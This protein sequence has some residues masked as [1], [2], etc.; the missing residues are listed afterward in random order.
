MAGDSAVVDRSNNM[1]YCPIVGA[2]PIGY[3]EAVEAERAEL[4]RERI[5]LWYVATTRAREL[6]ILPRLDVDAQSSAWISII[7]LALESLP[8]IDLAHLSPEVALTKD[9]TTNLQTREIFA[10]ECLL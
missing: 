10:S 4:T 9:K 3:E 7:E 8:A 5:R 6:L 1:F 2:K